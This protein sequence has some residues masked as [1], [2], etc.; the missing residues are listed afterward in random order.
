MNTRY[1]YIMG[2]KSG[3]GKSTICLGI[4]AQLLAQGYSPQQLAYIKPTTQCTEK[5]AVATFCAQQGISFVDIGGLIFKKGYTRDFIDGLTPSSNELL[6]SILQTITTI[7]AGKAVVLIDGIGSPSVGSVVGASNTNIAAL[8]PC[9]IIFVGK[10][11]IGAA[12]DDTV[13]N[14][15]LIQSKHKKNVGLIYNKIPLSELPAVQHYVSKRI[16]QLLPNT[17]P[18]GFIAYHDALFSQESSETIAAWFGGYVNL[19]NWFSE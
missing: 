6:A 1:L 11:G 9:R 19:T 2:S 3:V 5:Q 8:L 18:L 15:S 17:T 14:V 4:L 16:V 12:I 10:L 7:G 13:L